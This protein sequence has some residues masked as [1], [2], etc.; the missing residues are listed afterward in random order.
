MSSNCHHQ[1]G[2]GKTNTKSYNFNERNAKVLTSFDLR[3]CRRY[4]LTNKTVSFNLRITNY[5]LSNFRKKEDRKE[6]KKERKKEKR[7]ARFQA[8]TPHLGT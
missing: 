6:G 3:R 7:N 2:T 4:H 5:E 8:D 1:L